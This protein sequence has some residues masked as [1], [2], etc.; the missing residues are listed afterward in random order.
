VTTHIIGMLATTDALAE[1]FSDASVLQAMLDV[2]AALARAEAK[3]GIIP[4]EAAKAIARAAVAAEFDPA[5][6]AAEGRRTGTVIVPLVSALTT[7]VRAVDPDAAKFVHW[8]TTSQDVADT[9][10]SLLVNRA[11]TLLARDHEHLCSALRSLSDRHANDVMLGRTLLQPAPPITFGLKVAGWFAG[12][13]RTWARLDHARHGACVLQFGGASGTLAALG[14]K[15]LIV[16][17][18]LARGIGL[19]CPEA[20]W[21]AHRDRVAALVAACGIYTGVL[22]KMA[23]DVSLLM[24]HEVG[25]AAESGGGSSTMPHKQNPVGCAIALAAAARLPG[26]VATAIGSLVHEHERA[27]GAWHAE[28]P[29]VV[30]AV[31]TTGAAVAAL[32]EVAGSLV[33]DPARMRANLDRTNGLIFAERVM[34]QAGA[35]LGRDRVHELVRGLIAR[36]RATGDPLPKVV[37]ETPE[38]A[39]VLSAAD[40]QAL[41]DAQSYLGMAETLRHRLLMTVPLG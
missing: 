35:A 7:R 26:L 17:E 14:D 21:H 40:L 24:Q 12:A 10:L 23:R 37:R 28:W 8:G 9:A 19:P 29:T 36:A 31:Q 15:G 34:M 3:I 39:G 25:E 18:E 1:V 41:D 38:L 13:T 20:P 27:V 2:E 6:L 30:D 5:M 33:V 22:G 4:A 16:A 11:V 32:S